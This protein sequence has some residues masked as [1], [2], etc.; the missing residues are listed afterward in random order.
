MLCPFQINI[1][2][3]YS[4]PD[5]PEVDANFLNLNGTPRILWHI[6]FFC[7]NFVITLLRAYIYGF[8]QTVLA[9]FI[10]F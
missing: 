1:F 5:I 7:P 6:S 3:F 9:L 8:G 4:L 2:K 10:F